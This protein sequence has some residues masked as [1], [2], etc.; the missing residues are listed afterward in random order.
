MARVTDSRVICL[1]PIISNLTICEIKI[2]DSESD[3][4][5]YGVL[6]IDRS[7]ANSAGLNWPEKDVFTFGCPLPSSGKS[8]I[9]QVCQNHTIDS[10][11]TSSEWSLYDPSGMDD[12]RLL[13]NAGLQGAWE[14][15]ENQPWSFNSSSTVDMLNSTEDGSWTVQAFKVT[16]QH[17]KVTERHDLKITMCA[18]SKMLPSLSS[19]TA[20]AEP[21]YRWTVDP[22]VYITETLRK[23]LN[24]VTNNP[25]LSRPPD[26]DG[27]LA[28]D[29]QRLN[30]SIAE[31]RSG[32]WVKNTKGR[33]MNNILGG[34]FYRSESAPIMLCSSCLTTR[35]RSYVP[36]DDLHIQLFE[37]TLKETGSPARA[38]Q[39][40]YF[41]LERSV[42][43]DKLSSYA[44][45]ELADEDAAVAEI[46]TF[47]LTQI[48]KHCR[49][50]WAVAGILAAFFAVFASAVWL[51]RPMRYSLPGNSWHAIAQISESAQ[52]TELLRIARL[53]TDEEVEQ[54]IKGTPKSPLDPDSCGSIFC[55]NG[56][57]QRAKRRS[58]AVF[59]SVF[60]SG[61]EREVPRFVLREGVF[62]RASGEEAYAE[63]NASGFRHRLVR[64]HS[65]SESV[66]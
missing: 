8:P 4:G 22:A 11:L 9:W 31:V 38:L 29:K 57:L 12:I 53:S 21:N 50:Y 30:S 58:L 59:K 7:V 16:H 41:T 28:I 37:D 51:Y 14:T 45:S 64:K 54:M 49:G 47:K 5:I 33:M 27:T 2:S 66:D 15:W 56:S 1:R 36:L 48:P 65:W 34:L 43:Y 24:A 20:R 32:K 55:V 35:N 39:A 44:S 42:Y 10:V 63:L 62:V 3:I 40:L 13:W 26:Q 46:M 6:Q 17:L 61:P 60:A 25:L 19:Q 18:Q 52:L 23:Q